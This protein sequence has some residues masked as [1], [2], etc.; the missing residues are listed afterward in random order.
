M[1]AVSC[2]TGRCVGWPGVARLSQ[3]PFARPSLASTK[4]DSMPRVSQSMR[5]SRDG[6][7][8]VNAQEGVIQT[9]VN[10]ACFY[11]PRLRGAKNQRHL[12]NSSNTSAKFVLSLKRPKQFA[13]RRTQSVPSALLLPSSFS[14]SKTL[15]SRRTRHA[16]A[17]ESE[18]E[19][20]T[21]QRCPRSIR[22]EQWSLL[23]EEIVCFLYS[24]RSAAR[25]SGARERY[26][27]GFEYRR[28]WQQLWHTQRGTLPEV[29]H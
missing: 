6:A 16:K 28:R 24:E 12:L 18:N 8:A 25:I 11:W 19:E 23:R 14:A 15:E 4:N 26:T 29:S 7:L 27:R 2:G 13:L 1:F 22:L 3:V 17:A 5:I 21:C 20:T 9:C 10:I